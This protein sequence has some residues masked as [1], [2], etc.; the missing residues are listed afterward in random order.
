[1]DYRIKGDRVMIN[2]AGL[3]QYMEKKVLEL[4]SMAANLI[5]SL[6]ITSLVVLINYIIVPFYYLFLLI[7]IPLVARGFIHSRVES[8]MR[9]FFAELLEMS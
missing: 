2:R 7:L 6:I 3:G 1:M 4:S 9:R 8:W 5:I